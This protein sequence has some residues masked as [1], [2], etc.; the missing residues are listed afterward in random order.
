MKKRNLKDK[1]ENF[2]FV[3]TL[4]DIYFILTATLSRRA[5]FDSIGWG[6]GMAP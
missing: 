3:L 2:K 4:T 1:N 5:N 6:G